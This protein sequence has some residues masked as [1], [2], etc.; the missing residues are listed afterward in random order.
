[1][2]SWDLIRFTL[3]RTARINQSISGTRSSLAHKMAVCSV[4]AFFDFLFLRTALT[5]RAS[6]AGQQLRVWRATPSSDWQSHSPEALNLSSLI[7]TVS[8]INLLPLVSAP[9]AGGWISGLICFCVG[10][11]ISRYTGYAVIKHWGFVLVSWVTVSSRWYVHKPSLY[12]MMWFLCCGL[13]NKG[14]TSV[15]NG[16][17]DFVMKASCKMKVHF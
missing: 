7:S 12:G 15:L 17:S 2:K 8:H 16:N 10:R 14:L 13:L 9:K 5:L 4:S 6:E 11:W 3:Q 1:M